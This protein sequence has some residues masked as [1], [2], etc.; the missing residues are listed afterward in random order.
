MK[1]LLYSGAWNVDVCLQYFPMSLADRSVDS[2]GNC[3][4]VRVPCKC[5]G[6]YFPWVL[7]QGWFHHMPLQC[8][9]IFPVQLLSSGT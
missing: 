7:F 4:R 8:T 1:K 5:C 6:H 2:D 9:I 3:V